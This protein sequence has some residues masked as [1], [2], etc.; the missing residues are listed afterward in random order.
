MTADCQSHSNTASC[1]SFLCDWLRVRVTTY[2]TAE[3][4]MRSFLARWGGFASLV[5]AAV[6]LTQG[7]AAASSS[8]VV[9]HAYVNDNTAA[10][11]TI[12]VFD[13]HANGTLTP[14][15]GSPFAAGGDG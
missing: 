4:N 12:A 6:F 3:V 13:R 7:P 11:N 10:G 14:H 5:V 9:G 8:P 2:H 15:S 1:P